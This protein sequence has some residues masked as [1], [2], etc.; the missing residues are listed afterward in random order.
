MHVIFEA[1]SINPCEKEAPGIASD[2]KIR[3]K[4]TQEKKSRPA[5][6]VLLNFPHY[7][8]CKGFTGPGGT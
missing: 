4:R 6:L 5:T 3:K 7:H 2:K 8:P 1:I